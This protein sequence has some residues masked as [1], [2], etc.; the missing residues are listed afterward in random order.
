MRADG[1]PFYVELG[2]AI[3]LDASGEAI[4]ALATARDI[5]QRF[6]QDRESRRRLAELEKQVAEAQQA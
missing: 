4:G 2:F 5:T 3:L 1:S 6:E